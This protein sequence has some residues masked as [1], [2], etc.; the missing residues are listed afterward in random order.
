MFPPWWKIVSSNFS[1]KI[2]ILI[3]P[4]LAAFLALAHGPLRAQT[5]QQQGPYSRIIN[6][7]TEELKDFFK[8]EGSHLTPI[9]V[10]RVN[11]ERVNSKTATGPR[12]YEILWYR[13][14]DAIGCK[15]FN[16]LRISQS[17]E[18]AIKIAH[19]SNHATD[20]EVAA[21]ADAALRIML[22]LYA[23]F[24]APEAIIV[25]S[26]SIDRFQRHLEKF[27]FSPGGLAKPGE[28]IETS[29]VLTLVPTESGERRHLK[30]IGRYF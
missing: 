29:I 17:A 4:L 26:A 6:V 30:Y 23:D 12:Q 16:E 27:G 11:V 9:Y 20:S 15:R 21:A 3:T 22:D 10:A 7:Q 18:I 2:Q 14:K 1:R 13:G 19:K 5:P 25:P 24:N 8:F 28:P